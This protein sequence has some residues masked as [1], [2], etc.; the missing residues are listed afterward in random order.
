M[1]DQATTTNRKERRNSKLLVGGVEYD[2]SNLLTKEALEEVLESGDNHKGKQ[3]EEEDSSSDEEESIGGY[4]PFSKANNN[5]HKKQNRKKTKN[6][7]AAA[8]KKGQASS[9]GDYFSKK[10]QPPPALPFTKPSS[11]REFVAHQM[12]K[13]ASTRS[14]YRFGVDAMKILMESLHSVPE[15]RDSFH[16][17]HETGSV[18]LM[19]DDDDDESCTRS[20]ESSTRSFFA[21]SY[22]GWDDRSTGVASRPGGN[23]KNRSALLLGNYG[24]DEE[25]EE[26]DLFGPIAATNTNEGVPGRVSLTSTSTENTEAM[27]EDLAYI[28]GKQQQGSPPVG[29]HKNHE[30]PQPQEE[31]FTLEEMF[32]SA[33]LDDGKFDQEEE[34]ELEIAPGHYVPFRGGKETWRAVG[35]GGNAIAQLECFECGAHLVCLADCEYTVCPDCRVVNPTFAADDGPR[36]PFGVGM[37]FKKEWIDQRQQTLQHQRQQLLQTEKLKEQQHYYAAPQA[38]SL[39]GR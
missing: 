38:S 6:N 26:E 9:L 15:L 33:A 25:E 37:G 1:K 17:D 12:D 35:L 14:P 24:G 11:A 36:K 39:Y 32:R 19:D 28:Y 18:C 7:A 16:M 22:C 23:R 2:L 3:R 4:L 20:F 27:A 21:D 30:D 13:S 29:N 31:T 8:T 10:Q 5:H 34:C